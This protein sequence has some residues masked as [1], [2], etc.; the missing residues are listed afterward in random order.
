LIDKEGGV[1]KICKMLV[2]QANTSI[3]DVCD[4]L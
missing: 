1:A 4:R 3:I 2:F